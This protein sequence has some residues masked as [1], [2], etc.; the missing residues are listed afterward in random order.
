MVSFDDFKKV[1]IRIG[2]IVSAEEVIDSKKLLR[3]EVDLGEENNRQ[4][5]SGIAKFLSIDELVGRQVC[6]ASNLE[7]RELAGLESQGMIL[8]VGDGDSFSLIAPDK[9]VEPGTPVT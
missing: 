4:I 6:V 3:L 8:A 9:V 7:Y 5:I 1:E 2:K